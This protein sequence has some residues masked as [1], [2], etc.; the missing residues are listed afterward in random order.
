[1][2]TQSILTLG[3]MLTTSIAVF[4]GGSD[5]GGGNALVCFK[6]PSSSADILNPANPLRGYILDKHL[7]DIKSVTSYDLAGMA[8]KPFPAIPGES[9][10]EYIERLAKRFDVFLPELAQFL[11]DVP[12]GIVDENINETSNPLYRMFDENDAGPMNPE[13]CVIS[14]MAVQADVQSETQLTI[15]Q[16]L[17][18][19]PT[20]AELSKHVLYLHEYLY[21]A[22]RKDRAADK[23]SLR[24]RS[25]V[26]IILESN[27]PL[28]R[29]QAKLQNF[30]ERYDAP[31][32]AYYTPW[33]GPI[34]Q[35]LNNILVNPGLYEELTKIDEPVRLS[36]LPL[37]KELNDLV[38]NSDLW[39]VIRNL[40]EPSGGRYELALQSW[41]TASTQLDNFLR[42]GLDHEPDRARVRQLRA[43]I[44]KL[45]NQLVGKNLRPKLLAM[46]KS[47]VAHLPLNSAQ[48]ASLIQ[49]LSELSGSALYCRLNGHSD[50]E[51]LRCRRANEF[52][53]FKRG[54]IQKLG[55]RL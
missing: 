43:D 22:F 9:H 11:R 18:Q 48:Q 21:R 20:H 42:S 17:F 26:Q 47:S 53:K 44:Q 39:T 2:N 5:R 1:M 52:E 55:I 7:A 24:T 25:V 46:A 13:S 8:A 14:T 19:H 32:E 30:I 36:L 50:S 40:Q 34:D 49:S 45:I 51:V 15:D 23:D 31:G 28:D 54:M 33:M 12:N 29:L 27:V 6:S 10:A 16:R 4:A 3:L 38:Q 37:L 41:V 35:W